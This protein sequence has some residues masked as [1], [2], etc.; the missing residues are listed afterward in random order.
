MNKLAFYYF[1]FISNYII[2]ALTFNDASFHA[3]NPNLRMSEEKKKQQSK[4]MSPD[5]NCLLFSL[6]F[7]DQDNLEDL[8]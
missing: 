4:N 3:K 7:P 5:E 1:F 2:S 6:T 8:R